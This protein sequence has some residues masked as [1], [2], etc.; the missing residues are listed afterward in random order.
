MGKH[1]SGGTN[2][3]CSS[4]CGPY[5]STRIRFSTRAVAPA[6]GQR[7]HSAVPNTNGTA[8]SSQGR[9]CPSRIGVQ[10][11]GDAIFVDQPFG[12]FPPPPQFSGPTR[13]ARRQTAASAAAAPRRGRHLV[14]DPGRR[15][16]IAADRWA[17]IGV[18]ESERDVVLIERSG[19]S[20]AGIPP[21]GNRRTFPPPCRHSART[22]GAL[23]VSLPGCSASS[24]GSRPTLRSIMALMPS[25]PNGPIE[26]CPM[27]HIIR[28]VGLFPRFPVDFSAKNGRN[29]AAEPDSAHREPSARSGA[30]GR[31]ST[32]SRD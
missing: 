2:P 8:S 17:V 3:S 1:N 25:V 19:R 31:A 9:S 24:S 15:Q 4:R 18:R 26:R 20:R 10:V 13:S 22:A 11:I 12:G 14:V 5:R 27:G 28:I 23:G 21:V 6:A 32:G 7:F 16:I 29:P 30:A